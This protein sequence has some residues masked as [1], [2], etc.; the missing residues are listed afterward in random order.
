[1][2]ILLIGN[3]ARGH[4]IAEAINRSPNSHELHAAMV[5]VNPGIA[6]LCGDWILK[7]SSYTEKKDHQK[8]VIYCWDY[9]IECVIISPEGPLVSGIV[10]FLEKN[11]I[12]CIGPNKAAAL[13][14]GSK[15]RLMDLM[16]DHS[17]DGL[18][19]YR[20]ATDQKELLQHMSYFISNG[21]QIVIKK[22]GLC[23]GKGVMVQGPHFQTY[24]RG[25]EISEEIIGSDGK[26]LITEKFIGPEFSLMAF[27][28]AN[29]VSFM[30]PVRD[31][32]PRFNN[33]EGPNTGS[34]GSESYA[35]H[36]MPFLNDE[37]MKQSKKILSD[38][39]SALKS[40]GI[41][42]SGILYL[43]LIK[44]I[45]GIKVIETNARFGDPE[46]INVLS[47]L[48]TDF[49]L[50][51]QAIIDNKLSELD[52]VF[53]EKATVCVYI[54]PE[55]YA[56]PSAVKPE[57]QSD[58]IIIGDI[59]T[60]VLY[61]SADFEKDGKL[62]M[63]SSRCLALLGKEDTVEEA[64]LIAM[65]AAEEIGG[66]VDYRSDIGSSQLIQKDIDLVNSFQ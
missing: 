52:I 56:N 45:N 19:D 11:D 41:V 1:M 66:C 50:I 15:I 51:C 64:R 2:R 59:G 24:E 37:D 22:D 10:D 36:S 32:K 63:T 28:D 57:G 43:S 4:A 65:S 18:P 20:V 44:T 23:G 39:V 48:K 3:D 12:P 26:V 46:A 16:R 31:H 34:M 9:Q 54:V 27:V 25:M 62:H 38:I 6:N 53:E 5:S 49:V 7:L 42:Y 21:K 61:H 60:A 8:I 13:I 58:E 29:S 35:D 17:I 33:D 55:G 30:P 47:L 14:E 40:E